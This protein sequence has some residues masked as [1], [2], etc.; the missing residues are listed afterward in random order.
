[1][2]DKICP[3]CGAETDADLLQEDPGTY[4]P[5]EISHAVLD[6]PQ[7]YRPG[8][9]PLPGQPPQQRPLV[10]GPASGN[11]SNTQLPDASTVMMG[12]Q[13]YPQQPLSPQPDCAHYPPQ[14]ANPGYYGYNAPYM[15]QEETALTHIVE[16]SR[17]SKTTSPLLIR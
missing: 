4:N 2:G 3:Q 10:L 12:S 1:P 9:P 13:T 7:A 8:Q 5:T 17:R 11:Y 14:Q 16:A 15:T 6:P